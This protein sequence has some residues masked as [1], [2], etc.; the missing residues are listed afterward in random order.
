MDLFSIENKN[1]LITGASRGIGKALALGFKNAGA[2]VFATGSRKESVE[3]MNDA[4][5][6]PLWGDLASPETPSTLMKEVYSKIE[7]LHVLINNAG[8][9]ANMKAASMTDEVMDRIIDVNF[10]SVFRLSKLYYKEQTKR[11][12]S[13]NIINISSVLGLI[14]SNQ[15]SVYGATK[16]AL[17]QLTKNLALE[18]ARNGFRV[19]SICPG[20]IETDMISHLKKREAFVEAVKNAIPM[21]RFGQPEDLLGAAIFLASNA[22]AFMTGQCMVLDGGLSIP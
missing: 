11:K 15:V 2:N 20:Y 19:N 10:K 7:N 14:G 5:I 18:W 17:N 13:G 6:I 1:I 3:W 9:S 4:G 22:S 16:G 8:T 12:E 21:K